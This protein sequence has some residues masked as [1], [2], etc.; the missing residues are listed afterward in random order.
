VTLRVLS[1]AAGVTLLGASAPQRPEVVVSSAT[2]RVVRKPIAAQVV[3]VENL[4]P[5]RLVEWEFALA[6]AT[7]PDR[8]ATHSHYSRTAGPFSP[9]DGPIEAANGRAAAVRRFRVDTSDAAPQVASLTLVVFA[10]GMVDGTLAAVTE[11]RRKQAALVTD[12]TVW[13]T[14][15]DALPKSEADALRYLRQQRDAAIRDRPQDP[16]GIRGRVTQWLEGARPRGWA[17]TAA[18][19]LKREITDRLSAAIR[20]RSGADGALR[21]RAA[22]GTNLAASVAVR[23]QSGQG[24]EFV[25]LIEN[26]RDTPLEAWE[27][28]IYDG[29]ASRYPSS[30]RTE[31]ACAVVDDQPGRGRIARNE[32]REI[33]LGPADGAADSALPIAV[34]KT[35]IWSDLSWEGDPQARAERL[36]SREEDAQ[37]FAFWIAALK[38]AETRAS[39]S[40]AVAFLATKRDER[41]RVAPEESDMLA[42]NLQIWSAASQRTPAAKPADLAGYRRQLERQYQLLTRHVGK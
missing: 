33:S 38:S 16:S 21:D 9:G 20:Y 40:D 22:L 6:P 36:R 30:S 24:L 34:V 32:V 39:M 28:A 31:D 41:R 4:R 2:V 42:A 5:A 19:S 14:G 15:L 13:Q 11:F 12:L 8:P 37:R 7:T 25:A 23:P 17:F 10:D 35:A 27:L 26:L 3:F 18:D 29:P 1:V